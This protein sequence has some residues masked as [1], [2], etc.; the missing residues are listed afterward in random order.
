MDTSS[1]FRFVRL[2]VYKENGPWELL[3]VTLF[4]EDTGCCVKMHQYR[5]SLTPSISGPKVYAEPEVWLDQKSLS[6]I[7]KKSVF[8]WEKGSFTTI[9]GAQLNT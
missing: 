1:T 9:A 5:K 4:E 8:L 7:A 2:V 6:C 3:V